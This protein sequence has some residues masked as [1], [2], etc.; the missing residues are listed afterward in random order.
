MPKYPRIYVN[1]YPGDNAFTVVAKTL[2][3]LKRRG[4]SE[5]EREEFIEEL[6]RLKLVEGV[7]EVVGRWVKLVKV[8]EGEKRALPSRGKG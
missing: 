1:A 2:R 6:G 3:Q 8:G 4:V 7:W 5:E